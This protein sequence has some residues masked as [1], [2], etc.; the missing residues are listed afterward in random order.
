[1]SRVV[2][3]KTFPSAGRG[4]ASKV[5]VPTTT[6]SELHRIGKAEREEQHRRNP[7]VLGFLPSAGNERG[8]RETSMYAD[9]IHTYTVAIYRVV[10]QYRTIHTIQYNTI[11]TVPPIADLKYTLTSYASLLHTIPTHPR[12][13]YL[14]S[15]DLPTALDL[16]L[17]YYN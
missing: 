11:T 7:S 2:Q 8:E 1:M 15:P 6:V 13:V 10:L 3:E 14:P 9:A 4:S 5:N 17:K 16:Q 12:T